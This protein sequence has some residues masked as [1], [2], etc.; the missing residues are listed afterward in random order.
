MA[1]YSLMVLVSYVPEYL[2]GFQL[3]QPA[4]S[5]SP[6]GMTRLMLPI[7]AVT[8]KGPWPSTLILFLP[9]LF[10]VCFFHIIWRTSL[11]RSA[12]SFFCVLLM[13][14]S[15]P[16]ERIFFH[17]RAF[18]FPLFQVSGTCH[19]GSC[20][21]SCAISSEMIRV[22]ITFQIYIESDHCW[23]FQLY[24]HITSKITSSAVAQGYNSLICF[25]NFFLLLL[26]LFLFF[27]GV[28]DFIT[29]I[30]L[31]FYSNWASLRKSV[32]VLL[33]FYFFNIFSG[34]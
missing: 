11:F 9:V 24:C 20:T 10:W 33:Y 26:S 28:S 7:A 19:S 14:V 25:P 21:N 8:L 6:H 3:R 2:K 18:H 22:L 5:T 16:L 29:V 31:N 23:L 12:R 30:K 34:V 32:R 17:I 13:S 27:G 15:L 1:S 4:V